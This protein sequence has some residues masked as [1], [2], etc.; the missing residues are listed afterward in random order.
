MLNLNYAQMSVE[1]E[2]GGGPAQENFEVQKSKF[3]QTWMI[4]Y[5]D[6]PIIF[7]YFYIWYT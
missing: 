2:G 4:H 3:A 1:R 6:L 7:F 5:K